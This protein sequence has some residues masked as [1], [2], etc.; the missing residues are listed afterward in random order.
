MAPCAV[1]HLES[2]CFGPHL[3]MPLRPRCCD[4]G[5]VLEWQ[6]AI[7]CL[8]SRTLC[9]HA[10]ACICVGHIVPSQLMSASLPSQWLAMFRCSYLHLGPVLLVGWGGHR[11]RE[12]CPTAFEKRELLFAWQGLS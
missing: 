7:T 4:E 10:L 3:L 8:L 6:S 12:T 5:P 11:P 2:L 1:A 9:R